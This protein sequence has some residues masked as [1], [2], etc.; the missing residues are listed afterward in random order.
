MEYRTLGA[1]TLTFP[2][3]SFG[4][5]AI[6][7]WAWGGPRD[8]DAV[9]A[10]EYALDCG[11]TAI[12]TAPSYGMG[13]SERLVG[14]AVAGRR[15]RVLIATKCGV[16]WDLE[17]GLRARDVVDNEGH[18]CA[19][20]RNSRP[21]SLKHECEQSLKR[22]KT[23]YIDLYQIHWPDPT[24]S[25]DEAWDTLLDL[26]REGKVRALGVSNFTVDMLDTCF[27][28]GG[29]AS[30]QPKYNALQRNIESE[31]LPWCR[32]RGVGVLAYSPLAQGLLTGKFRPGAAFPQDDIR[33]ENPLFAPRNLDKIA[34]MLDALRPMAQDRGATL[35]QL[36]LAWTLAQP[37]IATVLAGVRDKHQ[38]EEN[39][40]AATIRLG[41]DEL[42]AIRAL[43]EGL[44]LDPA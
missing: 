31:I 28:K 12:D 20:Y 8:A 42:T 4:A 1:T 15:D 11:I 43:L 29:L 14:Q 27:A 44:S 41:G 6:G 40:R 25:L 13:H 36:F 30:L 9:A 7:G 10:L 2:A 39:A 37:G 32:D 26:Q 34:A 24:S 35:G 17:E 22:L 3:V 19:F 23:D 18:A 16:R 38:V 5:W 21:A 33:S